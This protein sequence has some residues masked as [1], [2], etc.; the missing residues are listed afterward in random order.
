MLVAL[1]LE[2]SLG[3][4][5]PGRPLAFVRR[6]VVGAA[7]TAAWVAAGG[8]PGL[9]SAFLLVL[10]SGAAAYG[11]ATLGI[12]L[13]APPVPAAAVALGV[14]LAAMTGLHWADRVAPLL[15]RTH[16]HTFRQ[17]VLDADPAL[18]AS[19]AALDHDRMRDLDVYVGVPL[20]SGLVR[21][22]RWRWTVALWLGLGLLL[23]GGAA[24]G[25]PR[26]RGA[27]PPAAAGAAP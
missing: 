9:A 8:Y 16:R 12:R 26:R 23:G 22:P 4:F 15:P 18:A 19:Y 25:R 21:A 7:G 14:L 6:G 13:A 2:T 1:V 11:V 24:V 5:T 10:A 27:P 17:A 3:A 20:A